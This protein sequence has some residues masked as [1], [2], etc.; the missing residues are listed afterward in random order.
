MQD[1]AGRVAFITGGASGIGLGLAR[2]LGECGAEL[3]LADIEEPA[4]AEAA[5]SLRAVR[6]PR[7]GFTGATGPPRAVGSGRGGSRAA[8]RR[9]TLS[10]RYCCR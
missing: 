5:R 10:G 8:V 4:L 2:A 6:R 7:A 9:H 3:A 1:F